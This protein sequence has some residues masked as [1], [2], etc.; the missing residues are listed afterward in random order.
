MIK[1]NKSVLIDLSA[2]Q[3]VHCGLG[4]VSLNFALELVKREL[5]N[6][7]FTFY[8][9]VPNN[10]E[11]YF[12]DKVKYVTMSKWRKKFYKLYSNYDLW[13]SIH[14][15]SPYKI[16]RFQKQ[17]LT[18][19]D[20]NFV[21]EKDVHEARV[22]LNRINKKVRRAHTIST[23]SYYV[24][25]DLEKHLNID[26]EVVKVIYNGVEYL[27]SISSKAPYF[28]NKKRPFFFTIGEVLKKKNFHVL[29]DMMELMPEYDLYICGNYSGEY[30]QYMKK[31]SEEL[32]N[33]FVS[34]VIDNSEKAWLYKNCETF[35]FP[36]ICEG[37]GLPV[38]EALQYGKHVVVSTLTC[39]P[40][41]GGEHVSYWDDFTPELMKDVVLN[42]IKQH[43]EEKSI[44][45]MEYS[46]KFNYQKNVD[47]YL[48]LY[49]KTMDLT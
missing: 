41:I 2:L 11:G 25:D 10:F 28:V 3:N 8:F 26:K 37:F 43:N 22:D 20:L 47:E 18:I 29:L 27:P 19:H 40:E 9:L 49:R 1:I 42:G 17:L 48:D 30:G 31:R 5:Q 35:F 32:Q 13:H 12:G 46:S 44:R 33:V 36:S 21:Y 23:I 34:G 24:L 7:P 15:H 14:Q 16:S 4:Q 39:L 45:A 38:I 6:E